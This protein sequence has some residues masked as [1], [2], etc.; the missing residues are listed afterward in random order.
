MFLK[1][2]RLKDGS[3]YFHKLY[4]DNV[5]KFLTNGCPPFGSYNWA[6]YL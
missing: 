3:I 2:Y 6:Y 1:K 4:F 5:P